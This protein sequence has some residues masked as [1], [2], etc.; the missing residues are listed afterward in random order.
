VTPDYARGGHFLGLTLLLKGQPKLVLEA[1]EREPA[2]L[3]RLPG[4]PLAYYA[5]GQQQNS[6][7]ALREAKAKYPGQAYQIALEHAYR[8]EIDEAFAWLDRAYEARDTGLAWL[9]RTDPMLANSKGDPRYVALL[10][11]M[12]LPEGSQAE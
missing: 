4:L 5:L 8:G 9:L 2:E 6:E 1:M 3:W 12:K 11:K 7:A 10:R